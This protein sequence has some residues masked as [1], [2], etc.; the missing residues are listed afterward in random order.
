[1]HD[2]AILHHIVLA[3]DTHLACLA[4]SS[5]RTILDIVV[6]FDN[7]S[8]DEALFEVGVDN[9]STLRSLPAFLIRPG[10]HLH[11]TSSDESLE[12]QQGISL[13]DEAV[14]TTL[15][16]SQFF[17][18]HQLVLV[19]VEFS[20]ILFRLSSYDHS[21]SAFFLSQSLNALGEVVTRL[22]I[23]LAYVADVEHG[24]GSEQEQ[25]ASTVLFL[26]RFEFHDTGIL[27]LIQHLFIGFQHSHLH[28]SLLIAGSSSLLRLSQTR[29][30][31]LQVFQLQF[32]VNNLLVA[33]RVDS[34]IHMGDIIVFETTQHMDNSIRFANVTKELIAQTLTL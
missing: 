11:L 7:L 25:I 2:V 16:Q 14:H 32:R 6:I 15:L 24:F 34:T 10:L 29:L 9:T 28:L 17:E 18:E 3:L 12:V 19:A 4:N 21:L 22:G 5:L 30:D 31:G 1:M 26:L 20:N 27:T 8:T 33:N 23:S 13:L